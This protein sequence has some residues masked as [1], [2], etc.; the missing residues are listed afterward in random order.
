MVPLV[1]VKSVSAFEDVRCGVRVQV[2]D[3]D[4]LRDVPVEDGQLGVE[5]LQMRVQGDQG[6][7]ELV[8]AAFQRLGDG[9]QGGGELLRL[10]RGQQRQ[11]MVEDLLQLDGVAGAVLR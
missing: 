10:H 6:A 1:V 7:A 8:A 11:H 3:L 5:L 2:A 9:G 4:E